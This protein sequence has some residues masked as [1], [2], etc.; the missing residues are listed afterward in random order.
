[1]TVW[2]AERGP[3][4]SNKL[5]PVLVWHRRAVLEHLIRIMQFS[6]CRIGSRDEGSSLVGHQSP[7][8]FLVSP[9]LTTFQTYTRMNRVGKEIKDTKRRQPGCKQQTL[10]PRHGL[11][12]FCG[13][14]ARTQDLVHGQ[15]RVNTPALRISF[16]PQGC[17]FLT[18][19]LSP[20]SLLPTLRK[21]DEHGQSFVVGRWSPRVRMLFDKAG[22]RA[23]RIMSSEG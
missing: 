10:P 11:L 6:F 2:K 21:L 14:V 5:L 13:V 12:F 1:M 3:G 19:M 22:N 17:S 18:A 20:T 23:S 16:L 4:D 9:P 8:F 7:G 15:A